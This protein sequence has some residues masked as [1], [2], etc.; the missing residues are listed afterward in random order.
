MAPE[1]E[2]L[3]LK[4]L[5]LGG[6]IV[7]QHLL[8]ALSRKFPEAQVIHI[9]A[10]TEA[11]V[12]FSVKDGLAGFP[13]SFLTDPPAG[14]QLRIK[15]GVLEIQNDILAPNHQNNEDR[16]SETQGWISTGDQVTI[17][18]NRVHFIGRTSGI[19]N[20]GGNKVQP[21]LVEEALNSHKAVSMSCAYAKKSPI[22]GELV[23]AD[24]VLVEPGLNQKS[25]R[26]ELKAY[27]V[28]KLEPYQTPAAIRFVEA[29]DTNASG[30]IVRK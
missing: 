15:D 13:A 12:G 9:F 2:R 6:E 1:H 30:K 4:G 25:V 29:L 14:I 7:D 28:D 10:S 20:V 23:A 22:T 24:V 16:P 21:E 17:C 3:S 8:N 5:T 26:L 11:G 18:D 27:L 19:I